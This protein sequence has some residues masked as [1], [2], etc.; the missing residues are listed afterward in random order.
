MNETMGSIIARL[1]KEKGLTQEQLANELGI[2]YQ[3]VSKWE[4]ELSSPDISA[5]PLLA[6]IFGVTVDALFGREPEKQEENEVLAAAEEPQGRSDGIEL[7]W[8]DD[9]DTLYVVLFAGDKL[10][11]HSGGEH[12]FSKKQVSFQYE[13]PALNIVSDFAVT[14]EGTVDGGVTAGGDVQCDV[15]GGDVRAEGD[16][17]C[18]AVGGSVNAGGDVTCDTVAGQVSAGGDVS[19]DDVYGNVSAG[20]D[21][22]CEDIYGNVS[23]GGDLSCDEVNGCVDDEDEDDSK[24]GKGFSFRIKL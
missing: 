21:V 3:A 11:G 15:V 14:V 1:R 5:L 18:D 22:S 17:T 8:P 20:G 19:C 13:G 7:P 2:S 9:K 6:D 10:I 12:L 23:A 24:R 4:N 16:V